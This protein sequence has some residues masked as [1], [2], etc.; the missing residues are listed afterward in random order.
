MS[1]N[2]GNVTCPE[3]HP[4]FSSLLNVVLMVIKLGNLKQG[5]V[6]VLF[7]S[8]DP[9]SSEDYSSIFSTQGHKADM[10]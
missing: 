4:D 10:T 7:G 3:A 1:S 6:Q 8:R 5:Q 9:R 2:I